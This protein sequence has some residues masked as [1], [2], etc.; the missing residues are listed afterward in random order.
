[1][2]VRVY[3]QFDQTSFSS[4]V[5]YKPRRAAL[6]CDIDAFGIRSVVEL[7]GCLRDGELN[8]RDFC[9]AYS[10][11][12]WDAPSKALAPGSDSDGTTR[13]K[14]TW[15]KRKCSYLHAAGRWHC[16]TTMLFDTRYRQAHLAH[17]H[18]IEAAAA[19]IREI[20]DA[21][22]VSPSWTRRAEP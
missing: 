15:A 17:E 9:R 5:F 3:G 12:T 20:G 13:A 19:A 14:N 10:C 22:K 21:A 11:A 6:E 2:D 18:R 7:A 8:W 16:L 1:M 4:V